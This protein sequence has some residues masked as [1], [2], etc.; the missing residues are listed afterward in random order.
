MVHAKLSLELSVV[1]GYI[2]FVLII[3]HYIFPI[4]F[5]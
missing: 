3:I 5:D 2:A 4:A 1:V